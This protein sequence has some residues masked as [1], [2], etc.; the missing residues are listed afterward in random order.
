[1]NTQTWMHHRINAHAH[2]YTH[3]HIETHGHIGARITMQVQNLHTICLHDYSGGE[4]ENNASLACFVHDAHVRM[5]ALK[6]LACR[7]SPFRARFCS[8]P[9]GENILCWRDTNSNYSLHIGARTSCCRNREI[10]DAIRSKMESLD[11]SS[12]VR[13]STLPCTRSSSTCK[14]NS[15]GAAMNSCAVVTACV[16]G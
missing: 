1:M 15:K 10:C 3:T 13:D 14:K 5:R 9:K 12:F 4:M 7:A 6:G 8:T 11:M 2:A 16:E